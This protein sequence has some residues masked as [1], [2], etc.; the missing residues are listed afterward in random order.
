MAAA[1]A[2]IEDKIADALER[3]AHK[4]QRAALRRAPE[5]KFVGQGRALGNGG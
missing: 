2:V 1:I 3:L 4:A 5:A